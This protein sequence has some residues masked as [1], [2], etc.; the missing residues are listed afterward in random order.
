M[1]SF[2]PAGGKADDITLLNGGFW[3]TLSVATCR[4]ETGLGSDWSADRIA[5]ELLAVTIDVNASL[6]DWRSRQ[7]AASLA[8]VPA[9]LY[10]G[11]SEKV[12][13]Y[14]RAV[15]ALVRAE[16]LDVTRDYDSTGKGHARADALTTTADSWRAKAQTAL[17]RLIGRPATVVELI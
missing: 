1:T 8:A 6:S 9:P 12:I 15:Y 3:P 11:T 10:D 2:I 4:A 7:A 5:A 13:L 14:R 16:Q 17:A